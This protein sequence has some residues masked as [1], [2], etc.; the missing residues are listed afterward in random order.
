MNARRVCLC[1]TMFALLVSLESYSYAQTTK[2]PQQDLYLSMSK[3][4][5]PTEY[6][7]VYGSL[8]NTSANNYP[9]VLL[10]FDLYTRY[11]LR[12]PGEEAK[13]LGI[14]SVEV[15][16]LQPGVQRLFFRPLPYPAGIGAR[17]TTEC[18]EQPNNQTVV[19]YENPN[20]QGRSMTFGIGRHRLFN[21]EDFNDVAASIKVPKGLV[22]IVYEHADEAGGYG[23]WIDFL[24]DHADLRTHGFDKKI[25]Y[26]D[27]FSREKVKPA[28]GSTPSETFIY[29]RNKEVNGIFVP[30]NW[31]ELSPTE[32]N[33]NSNPVAGPPVKPTPPEILT[34][35]ATPMRI[36]KGS[37]ATLQWNT[38]NTDAVLLGEPNAPRAVGSSGSL[39]VNPSLTTTYRLQVKHG[40]LS[41]YQDVKIE[42]IAPPGFCTISVQID[43]DQITYQTYIELLH[44]N[45][46]STLKVPQ[47]LGLGKY[48]FRTVREGRYK[49]KVNGKYPKGVGREG[50]LAP[51]L[52]SN[53]ILDCQPN[54]NVLAHYEI[55]STE[56]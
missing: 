39:Q 10:Q 4:P 19:I 30:G 22:A 50:G 29:A 48:I 45:G 11:D 46:S 44:A 33:A 42:V 24:E 40:G 27:V 20:F 3:A 18:S 14:L 2:N 1:V 43:R 7:A 36:N 13:H 52:I 34:F 41:T 21:T 31:I 9:C 35:R 53:E 17:S 23:S 49:V 56:G 12:K 37:V 38:K 16:N 6:G 26:L 28:N 54:G 32:L 8:K 55:R 15:R 25:S 47:K 5:A 51:F